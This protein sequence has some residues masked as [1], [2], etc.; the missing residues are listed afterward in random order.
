VSAPV[1]EIQQFI[2]DRLEENVEGIPGWQ[3]ILDRRLTKLHGIEAGLCTECAQPAVEGCSCGQS[4]EP[5]LRP[6]NT[7]CFM[8]LRWAEHAKFNPKW[9]IL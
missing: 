3:I 4:V 8:A 5:S 2:L 9:N 1:Q 6:C 7:L